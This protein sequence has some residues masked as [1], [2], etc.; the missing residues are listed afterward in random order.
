MISVTLYG[1]IAWCIGLFFDFFDNLVF[2]YILK[3]GI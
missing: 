2:V 3:V 1:D